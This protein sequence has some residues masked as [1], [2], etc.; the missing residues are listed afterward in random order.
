MSLDT[1]LGGALTSLKTV[2]QQISLVSNNINNANTPGYTRKGVHLSPVGDGVNLVGVKISD[3]T[4]ATDSTLLKQLNASLADNDKKSVQNQYLSQIQDILGSSS[5]TVKLTNDVEKFASAWRQLQAEPENSALQ[6]QVIT[7]GNSFASDIRSI[8]TKVEQLDGA[9]RNDTSTAVTELNRSLQDVQK[10]NADVAQAL[11]SGQPSGDYEDRRDAAL[12]KIAQYVDIRV[13]Q[14]GNGQVAVYT[15]Y[16]YSLL[17]GTASQFAYT[18][19][20]ITL[21]GSSTAVN[22]DLKGGRLEGLLNLRADTSPSAADPDATKEVV[23]KLR[24]QLDALVAGFTTATTSPD[25]FAQAYNSATSGTGELASGFFTGTTRTDFVVNASLLNGSASVKQ[26]AASPVATAMKDE[27]RSFTAFGQTANNLSYTGFAQDII[28]GWQ[29][30]A[31]RTADE[32]KTADSQTSYFQKLYTDKTAVN[33][34][35]ELISL[36]SLQKSY[37][38]AARVVNAVDAMYKVLM[39]M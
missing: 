36:Q 24:N 1:A 2:Q 18:S 32:A 20:N 7:S 14:R 21:A 9:I 4:R 15:P 25:S 26:L 10:A 38:A 35:E 3:Y 31:N 16:G 8:A 13:F 11:A 33:V 28:A 5:D 30:G 12:Q 34:D 19:G 6:S 29:S 37:Q 27:T 17:D 23:R 22:S 39:N